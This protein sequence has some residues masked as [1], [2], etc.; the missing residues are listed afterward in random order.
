MHYV[1][2]HESEGTH[3]YILCYL[4][5]G[6]SADEYSCPSRR[7]HRRTVEKTVTSTV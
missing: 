3:Y 1:L 5:G 2:I 4:I 7:L 6:L